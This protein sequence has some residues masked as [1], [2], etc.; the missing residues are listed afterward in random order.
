MTLFGY[1]FNG[2]KARRLGH[3]IDKG[4]HRM[5]NKANNVLNKIDKGIAKTDVVLRKTDNTLRR[6]ID[7][8]AGALPY[9]GQALAGAS[10]IVHN[11]RKATKSM[12]NGVE[13]ARGHAHDLEKFNSRKALEQAMTADAG[14]AFV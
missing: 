6:V 10:G 13:T 9:V 5:G 14:G 7:S 3:K 2:K 1:K 12:K 4:A 8:G 11:A